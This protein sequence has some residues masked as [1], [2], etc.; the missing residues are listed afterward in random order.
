MRGGGIRGE[1]D[2]DGEE[3]KEEWTRIDR[4]KTAA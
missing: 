3:R 1:K 2:E 4:M